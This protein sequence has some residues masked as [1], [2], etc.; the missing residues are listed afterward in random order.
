MNGKALTILNPRS[1]FVCPNFR[2]FWQLKIL[3]NSY[4]LQTV[5][6]KLS[7]KGKKTEI[8]KEKPK[9]KYLP[10]VKVL[11][12]AENENRKSRK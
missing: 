10:L 12:T 2:G 1:F 8:R 6:F 9:V 3:K 11:L 4:R 7:E 5:T